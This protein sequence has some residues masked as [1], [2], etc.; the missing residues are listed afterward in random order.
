MIADDSWWLLLMDCPIEVLTWACHVE[1]EILWVE[2]EGE[3]HLAD[4]EKTSS[5][6]RAAVYSPSWLLALVDGAS[7]SMT[8][9]KGSE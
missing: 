4:D 7:I 2:L 1:M 3:P 8:G 5:E 9:R 6:E